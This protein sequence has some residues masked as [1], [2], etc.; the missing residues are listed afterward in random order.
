MATKPRKRKA[1]TAGYKPM[2]IHWQHWH[3]SLPLMTWYEVQ[4]MLRD[5]TIR[6]GLA[7]RRAPIQNAEFAYKDSSGEWVSGIKASSDVIAAYVLRQLK[8]I[9]DNLDGLLIAQIWGWAGAEVVCCKTLSGKVEISEVLPRHPN[10]VRAILIDGEVRAV[11]FLRIEDVGH[12]DLAVG[13]DLQSLGHPRAIFHAH[14]PQPGGHY[15]QSILHGAFSP[16]W[17]KNGPGGALKVRRLAMMQNSI[18]GAKVYY[19]TGEMSLPGFERPVPNR[20]IARQIAETRMAGAV[21]TMPSVFTPD[22]KRLWEMEDAKAM[23]GLDHILQYPKDCDIEM[24]RGME[25]PDDVIMS[26]TDSSG[27]WAGKQVPQSAFYT[28]LTNWAHA[29]LQDI[30]RCI[31]DWLVWHNFGPGHWYELSIKSLAEQAMEQ[32]KKPQDSQNAGPGGQGPQP[33]TFAG[34]GNDPRSQRMSL[35]PVEAVGQGVL[36]ASELVKA[37][38]RVMRLSTERLRAPKGGVTIKGKR[39][40]GG[41]FIP[42]GVVAKMS[43]AEKA[44]VKAGG[45]SSAGK[46]SPPVKARSAAPRVPAKPLSDKAARARQFHKLVDKDIQRYAEEHN[47]PKFAKAIGGVSFPNGEPI[48]VAVADKSGRV[49]HGIELKTMVDNGNNKITMKRDAMERKAKWE[50]KNKAPIHTVV[51]DDSAVFNANGPGQ[52]DPSKRR[53]FYRRGYGSFRVGTM[54]EV[55]SVK[56]LKTLMDLPND[57]LPEPARRPAGQKLGRLAA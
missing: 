10:D 13:D 52:H 23:S 5:P 29:L 54:H 19:P 3:D 35:D 45:Q 17:D 53:I 32:Q 14:D 12:V 51:I 34:Q 31:L 57:S 20:D 11:R 26:T 33:F 36:S 4:R 22:G 41:E 37:A 56:E 55:K 18:N 42:K 39:Y 24:L 1:A 28:G 38:G 16:W 30:K 48:D 40:P 2:P 49:A 43:E 25:I 27:A 46:E 8:K 15:G 21:V 44:K 50:R 6:L 47:E 7:M 9:W